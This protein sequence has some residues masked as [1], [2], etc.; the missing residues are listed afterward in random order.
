M[1]A[2]V[3]RWVA[4]L[5]GRGYP[6]LRGAGLCAGRDR[7]RHI[8][9]LALQEPGQGDDVSA[10]NLRVP[11]MC[12]LMALRY[13]VSALS[14]T[15][16][17]SSRPSTKA[18]SGAASGS[19]GGPASAS[20]RISF[21]KSATCALCY[22]RTRPRRTNKRGLAGKAFRLGLSTS[23]AASGSLQATRR[24]A[25]KTR[26]VPRGRGERRPPAGESPSG[27]EDPG[28][29]D[30]NRR[31]LRRYPLDEDGG[32]RSPRPLGTK[33]VLLAAPKSRCSKGTRKRRPRC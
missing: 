21:S 2:G 22:R 14:Y 12:A 4:L 31:R 7:R 17:C 5:C 3:P 18:A 24:A 19:L 32:R 28:A 33:R 25:S 8:A 11:A 9:A 6:F 15:N 16:S 23:D 30:K 10:Y 13:S 29:G 20:A 26:L 27:A 1:R